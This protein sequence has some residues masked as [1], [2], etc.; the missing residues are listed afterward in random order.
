MID[1]GTYLAIG[2]GALAAAYLVWLGQRV[3][4]GRRAVLSEWT[5][6]LEHASVERVRAAVYVVQCDERLSR[7]LHAA[8]VPYGEA[9]LAV[10]QMCQR[11]EQQYAQRLTAPE[12]DV[13]A[14]T[15][16]ARLLGKKT[17]PQGLANSPSVPQPPP[18]GFAPGLDGGGAAGGERPSGEHEVVTGKAVWW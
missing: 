4:R 16:V 13:P 1:V 17:S 6:A 11:V 18:S 10:E 7:L 9:V 12:A 3:L 14:P 5:D 15:W 2:A 8:P